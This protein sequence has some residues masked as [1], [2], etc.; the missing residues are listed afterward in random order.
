VAR[1][2]QDIVDS[3]RNRHPAFHVTRVPNTVAIDYLSDVHSGALTDAADLDQSRVAVQCSI[4]FAVTPTNAP[5]TVGAGTAGGLPGEVVA[6]NPK[7]DY[8][9]AGLLIL[10]DI[11]NA[12]VD[13]ADTAATGG[14]ATTLV[15]TG[16]GWG[17]NAKQNKL[18]AIVAGSGTGQMRIVLSNTVD[19]LTISTGSDGKQW[20]TIPD[21]TSIF[22]IVTQLLKSDGSAPRAFTEIPPRNTKRGFLVSLD[23]NGAPYINLAAPIEMLLDIGIP[24]PTHQHV[25]GG[26][27][28][29]IVNSRG[30]PLTAALTIRNYIDRYL[31]GPSYTVWLENGQLFLAGMT[32]DWQNVQSIDLRLVP[33]LVDFTALTDLILLPDFAGQMLVAA[34]ADFMAVRCAGMKDIDPPIDVEWFHTERD[35]AY[36]VFLKAIGSGMRAVPKYVKEAW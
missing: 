5:G 14:S 15:R 17:V 30:A 7:M 13:T 32:Q 19:T 4:G 28:R 18:V 6:G 33:D 22:R 16:S 34:L 20:Q 24:L 27:V 11:D 25:I 31:W 26:S 29:L 36:A 21:A 12:I 10:E 8:L 1:T 23:A 35:K 9:D 2:V 3:A